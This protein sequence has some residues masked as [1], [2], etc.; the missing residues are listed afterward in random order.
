MRLPAIALIIIALS[1]SAITRD[2]AVD[3]LYS[4]MSLPDRT[5]YTREFYLANV[6]ASLRAR[7]E[8][9]WGASV[10]EREFMHFVLPVRVNNEN[11]DNSRMVFYDELKER[12]KGL[13]MAEAIL[14]VN[15]WCHEK[16]TYKPSDGRTSS[17]LS[18]VSQA[19]GRCGEESTF[20]VAAL[21]SVGIPA[22]QIYTPR[23]AHTD[24]NHAWVEAWADGQWHFIGACEPE[25]VLDLAWFNAP[26]S[27]GILM[28]TNV[29]GQYSGPEEVLLR[30]PMT[31]RINVTANYA[32]VATLPVE[33]VF[34]DGTP[35]SGAVVNF[36][37]YNYAEYFPAVTKTADSAGQA[38]LT[39]GLGDLVVWATDGSSYGIAKGSARTY[40]DTPSAAPLRVVL[41]RDGS[42]A[43]TTEFDIT[44]PRAGASLPAVPADLRQANDRRLQIEDSI[45]ASY[46]ATF[47]TPLRADSIASLL[48]V[49][50][51]DMEKILVESRGNHQ[52]LADCLAALDPASRRKAVALLLNVSEKD[53]RDI[54]VEV[55]I[56]HVANTPD[57]TSG[58]PDDFYNRYLLC[59]RV[60]NEMLT[61]WRSGL[62][63]AFDAGQ[64][65][66]FAADPSLLVRWVTDSIA[67]AGAENPQNHRM[68]PEGVWRTRKADPLSRN[69]FFVAMARTLGI[70]AR[71]DPVTGATQYAGSDMQW[72]TA[73]F[74]PASGQ[75]NDNGSNPTSTGLLRLTFTPEGHIVDPLYYS[76]F[77]IS[78]IE[79]GAPRQLEFPEGGT[80]SSIFTDPVELEAGQYMLTTGQRMADGGVLAR[81]EVFNITPGETATVPLIIRHDDSALSV[82]GSLNAENIYH[83]LASDT[84]RSILSTT[85]R[86][87]YILG[88][89]SPS[90]EPS[91]HALNDMSAVKERLEKTGKKVMLLFDDASSAS[92]FEP[93]LFSNLPSN[94]VFGI[95]ND[96]ATRRELTESLHLTDPTYP[97]LSLIHI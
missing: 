87:Y 33:V 29:A 17:P 42:S 78:R 46:T 36:C 22:R 60:E 20:T 25:P 19:I 82:I 63:D 32:P 4:T 70:P 49:N 54:P 13:G 41:D 24:D 65:R 93:S 85:G 40:A 64:R 81:S 14:E 28:S 94:A 35:A 75:G 55:I 12:V 89:I 92:R 8:M 10:P 66:A 95:D 48:G 2:E 83:D 59:P 23:W 84:D 90:H 34:P 96:G 26:A 73:T 56:D 69:I 53:R 3:F 31:T 62:A 58:L 77:S 52:R 79:N 74:T 97:I 15:H 61:T 47:A 7:S 91:A 38:S 30:Q 39:A 9:P 45:R 51:A 57:N 71:I 1:S 6:D 11:L 5:D 67:P 86:G 18:S 88:L 44:P 80:F 50:T 37:I 16:V 27:R 76:Q 43:F 21:R 72:I 68:S